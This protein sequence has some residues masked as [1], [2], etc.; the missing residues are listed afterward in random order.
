MNTFEILVGR[1]WRSKCYAI[2]VGHPVVGDLLSC[3]N[4]QCKVK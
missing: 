2:R 1:M 4:G 3:V